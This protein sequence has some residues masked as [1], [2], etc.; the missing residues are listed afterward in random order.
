MVLYLVNQGVHA[1][2]VY[3]LACLCSPLGSMDIGFPNAPHGVV[4]FP[5]SACFPAP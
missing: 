2:G 5:A 3:L 1:G 4:K